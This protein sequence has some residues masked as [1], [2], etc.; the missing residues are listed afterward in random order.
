MI[1][2]TEP[3]TTPIPPPTRFRFTLRTVFIVTATVG[4]AMA[5]FIH[6][7]PLPGL[8]FA[9]FVVLGSWCYLRGKRTGV[10]SFLVLYVALWVGLQIFGPYTSLRNRIVWVV[11]T[12]RLQQWAVDTLGE[13]SP[14]KDG[15]IL[16]DSNA[17]PEDICTVAGNRYNKVFWLD[18]EDCVLFGHGYGFYHWGIAVGRPGWKPFAPSF[19]DEIADGIW[20]FND[21]PEGSMIG[22]SMPMHDRRSA[23]GVA[24]LLLIT[25]S[26]GFALISRSYRCV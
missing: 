10:V 13:P 20:G 11:G 1:E 22:I 8:F 2:P 26:I 14:A 21:L 9:A 15:V 19:F 17:L 24:I 6:Y 23:S 16:L 18:T 7:G 4:A 12:D 5:L 25:G 3:T